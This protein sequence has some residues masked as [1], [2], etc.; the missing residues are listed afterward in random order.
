MP[1]FFQLSDSQR[2]A[3]IEKYPQLFVR[4]VE[5]K[6]SLTRLPLVAFLGGITRVC[7]MPAATADRIPDAPR[8]SAST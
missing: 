6:Y 3:L 1:V 2:C 5:P 7:I 4:A 8:R